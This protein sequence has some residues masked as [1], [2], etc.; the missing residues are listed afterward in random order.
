MRML[1]NTSGS[2]CSFRPRGGGTALIVLFVISLL[3]PICLGAAPA[4]RPAPSPL[5]LP[6]PTDGNLHVMDTRHYRI[7]TDLETTF[8][9]ELGRRMNAMYDDYSRRL[10]DF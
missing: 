5:I 4:P 7:H 2:F 3:A 8:A 6:A 10:Q 9:E 1:V